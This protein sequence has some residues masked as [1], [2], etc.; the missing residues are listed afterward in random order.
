MPI[1]NQVVRDRRRKIKNAVE[2]GEE[3]EEWDHE[4]DD[5]TIETPSRR[6]ETD[7]QE[8]ILAFWAME[9]GKILAAKSFTSKHS[10]EKYNEILKQID[11]I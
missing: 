11:N 8:S 6:R 2:E 4:S 5:L 1:E 10:A 3:E 7:Q 9:E